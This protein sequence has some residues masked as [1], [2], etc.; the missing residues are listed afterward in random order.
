MYM[1]KNLQCFRKHFRKIDGKTITKAK[2]DT[3][4]V[5]G[6]TKIYQEG[7]Q[8]CQQNSSP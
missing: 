7:S 2:H 8:I 4:P 5:Y 3:N 1:D 6:F